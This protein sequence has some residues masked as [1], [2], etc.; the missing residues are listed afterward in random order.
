MNGKC[1]TCY[2]EV[3]FTTFKRKLFREKNL[4]FSSQNLEVKRSSKNKYKAN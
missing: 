1:K 4:T 2:P 3:N